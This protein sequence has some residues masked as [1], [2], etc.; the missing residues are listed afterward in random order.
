MGIFQNEKYLGKVVEVSN[1][2][3]WVVKGDKGS[4]PPEQSHKMFDL[5][6]PDSLP[7]ILAWLKSPQHMWAA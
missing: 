4:F 7:A 5:H 1:T 3:M 6:D 2:K